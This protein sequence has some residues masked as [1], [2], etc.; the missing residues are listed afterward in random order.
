MTVYN[1]QKAKR[2]IGLY[3]QEYSGD[4]T[5]LED[6]VNSLI[7]LKCKEQREICWNEVNP[8]DDFDKIKSAILNSPLPKF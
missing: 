5:D 2:I 7:E 3:I 1:E 8:N 6:A 4:S